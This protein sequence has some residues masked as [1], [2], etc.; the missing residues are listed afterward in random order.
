MIPEQRMGYHSPQT[1]A[2][3]SGPEQHPRKAGGSER[4]DTHAPTWRPAKGQRQG[5]Q[6]ALDLLRLLSH[7]TLSAEDRARTLQELEPMVRALEVGQAVRAAQE[8]Q[9]YAMACLGLLVPGST[10]GRAKSRDELVGSA[11][12]AL[13][14]LSYR[15][16][17][18]LR[19][20]ECGALI[21]LPD[22]E[23]E[24]WLK[25]AGPAHRLAQQALELLGS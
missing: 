6:R 12:E 24:R 5:T 14:N 16:E 22:P 23:R 11:R 7:P 19:L 9:H 10:Q 17:V 1:A 13:H 18:L 15:L 20:L 8:A 2:G 21:H 3:S 4:T 25:L